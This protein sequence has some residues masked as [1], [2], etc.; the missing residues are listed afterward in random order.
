MARKALFARC[1]RARAIAKPEMAVAYPTIYRIIPGQDGP[2]PPDSPQFSLDP[3]LVFLGSG[4]AI[5]QI[6]Y[7]SRNL[8]FPPALTRIDLLTFVTHFRNLQFD[9]AFA[10]LKRYG[11]HS[12]FLPLA[13]KAS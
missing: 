9:T 13:I 12:S 7:S 2:S 4:F 5:V 3:V 8:Y 6:Q 1:T 11:G 10:L